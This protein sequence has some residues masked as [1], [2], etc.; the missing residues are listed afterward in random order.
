MKLANVS[1][2]GSNLSDQVAAKLME[3]TPLVMHFIRN[4]MKE[5]PGS[6]TSVPQIRVMA[7]IDNNPGCSLSHLSDSLGITSASASTMI[8]RLVR[9]GLVDRVVDPLKRRNLVLHLTPIGHNDLRSARQLAV[10]ALSDQLSKLDAQQLKYVEESMTLLKS[11]F[12]KVNVEFEALS[13]H[14]FTQV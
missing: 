7:F 13:E 11:V 3:T 6:H 9:A 1:A 2:G 14:A 10:Q 5:R 4:K 8:D 12:S